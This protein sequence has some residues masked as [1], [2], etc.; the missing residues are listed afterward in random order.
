M[1]RQ[2]SWNPLTEHFVPQAA[3]RHPPSFFESQKG[4][5]FTE[6]V[7]GLYYY[8]AAYLLKDD[9][10]PF[11]L[12]QYRNDSRGETTIYLNPDIQDVNEISRITADIVSDLGLRE[13]DVVWQ[14]KDTPNA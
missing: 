14:R 3:I 6:D 13:D 4:I 2:H 5:T 11:L 12:K 7:D 9:L 10:I 8:K 1:I